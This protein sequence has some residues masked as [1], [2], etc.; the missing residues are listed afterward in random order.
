MAV[1]TLGPMFIINFGLLGCDM[2][3]YWDAPIEKTPMH[4]WSHPLPSPPASFRSPYHRC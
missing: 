1:L 2:L 4:I 3:G